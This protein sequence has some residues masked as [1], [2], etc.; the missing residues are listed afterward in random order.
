MVNRIQHIWLFNKNKFYDSSS[1]H[2]DHKRLSGIWDAIWL[3]YHM[4]SYL[5]HIFL[6]WHMSFNWSMVG[7]HVLIVNHPYWRNKTLFRNKRVVCDTPPPHLSWKQIE[8]HI[9]YYGAEKTTYRGGNRHIHGNM[10]DYYGVHHNCHKK[11][12]FWELPYQKD[13]LLHPTLMWCI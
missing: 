1:S 6:L 10:L 13:L 2:M 9:D 8:E 3:G 7:R 5:V 11:S 12:I 4:R